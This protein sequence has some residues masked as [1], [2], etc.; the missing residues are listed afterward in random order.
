MKIIRANQLGGGGWCVSPDADGDEREHELGVSVHEASQ[1][2]SVQNFSIARTLKSTVVDDVLARRSAVQPG[3]GG[4]FGI[5]A[6]LAIQHRAV[7]TQQIL[8]AQLA[9]AGQV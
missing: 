6:E 9:G 7:V 5:G 8:G 1:M 4:D 3:A 2:N